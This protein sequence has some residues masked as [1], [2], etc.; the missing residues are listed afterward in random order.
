LELCKCTDRPE[1]A[2]SDTGI[3]PLYDSPRLIYSN[4][5]DLPQVKLCTVHFENLSYDAKN[6]TMPQAKNYSTSSLE[7]PEPRPTAL[8]GIQFVL[9]CISILASLVGIA[10]AAFVAI[11]IHKTWGFVFI[12]VSK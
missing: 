9:R 2:C 4:D 12:S 7:R 6:F 1:E 10:I 5:Q 3:H 8:L 11:K